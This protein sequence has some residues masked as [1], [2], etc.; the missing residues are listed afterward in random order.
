MHT[1]H[2]SQDTDVEALDE[3][4]DEELSQIEGH[5]TEKKELLVSPA[6]SAPP[7]HS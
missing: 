5:E 4:E 1:P 2:Y 7:P 6:P 3:D